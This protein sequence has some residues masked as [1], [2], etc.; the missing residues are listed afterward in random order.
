MLRV[1]PEQFTYY[2]CKNCQKRFRIASFF[3]LAEARPRCP[4]C[5]E[6]CCIDDNPPKK[7]EVVVK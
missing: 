6:Y 3:N 1:K 7:Q 4:K 5:N 2:I